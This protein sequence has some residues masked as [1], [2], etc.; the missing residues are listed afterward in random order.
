MG[1]VS[2]QAVEAAMRDICDGAD[3]ADNAS[4]RNVMNVMFDLQH[5]DE[6]GEE[7]ETRR[8]WEY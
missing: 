4:T 2:L 3:A 6:I 7:T 1:I 8:R 5:S